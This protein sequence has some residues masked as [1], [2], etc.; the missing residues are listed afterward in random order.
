MCEIMSMQGDERLDNRRI[1][2]LI[3]PDLATSVN[4]DTLLPFLQRHRLVTCDESYQLGN[5]MHASSRKAQI[6]LNGLKQKGNT[7]LQRFLCCLNSA[8][9]HIG[10]EE[11]ADK[12][13]QIMRSNGFDYNDFC[14]PN[15]KQE[16]VR[17]QQL[18]VSWPH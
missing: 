16:Y 6:L 7:C 2:E 18:K 4:M 11:I 13:K 1:L 5:I 10:H 17:K 15:C 14:S 3:A 8:Y 12:L 9:E